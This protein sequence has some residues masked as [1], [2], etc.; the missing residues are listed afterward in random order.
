MPRHR[1]GSVEKL[2]SIG[3]SVRC[4]AFLST[5][6]LLKSICAWRILCL[7]AVQEGSHANAQASIWFE[8]YCG[9]KSGYLSSELQYMYG[10]RVQGVILE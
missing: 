3:L 7:Y 5:G 9:I 6:T 10:L 1:C 8:G 2:V 4:P